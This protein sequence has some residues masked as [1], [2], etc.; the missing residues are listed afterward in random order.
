M[1][2][3][4][5]DALPLG[6]ARILSLYVGVLN[7]LPLYLEVQETHK[8]N[9]SYLGLCLFRMDYLRSETHFTTNE[10]RG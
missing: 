1:S 10:Y 5:A 6:D 9:Q 3:W 8:T 4:K 7:I 2:A